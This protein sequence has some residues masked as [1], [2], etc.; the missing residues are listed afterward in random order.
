MNRRSSSGGVLSAIPAWIK[1]S[2]PAILPSLLLAYIIWTLGVNVVYLD[3][4]EMIPIMQK[5]KIGTLAFSDLFLQQ[6]DHRIPFAKIAMLAIGR[7]TGYNTT[8][9]MFFGWILICLSTLLIFRVFRNR[10]S[11]TSNPRFA[12]AFM[13]ASLLLFS[14]C[15]Y[16]ATLWGFEACEYLMCFAV[17]A[18]FYLIEKSRRIDIAFALCVLSAIV[19]SFSFF[20]VGL[21]VWPV[22]MVQVIVSER[23]DL[24]K[25]GIL[26]V[27]GLISFVA[28]F[29]RY[30]RNPNSELSYF[31]TAPLTVGRYFFALVGAPFSN[32]IFPSSDTSVATVFGF[33]IAVIGVFL[34]VQVLR[35]KPRLGNGD[36]IWFSLVVFV[37]LCSLGNAAGR[38]TWT[39]ANALASRYTPVTILG[40]VGLYLF[41]LSISKSSPTRSRRIAAHALLAIILLG[42]AV[43]SNAAWQASQNY[44]QSREMDAYVL[45]TYNIQSDESIAN[46]LFPWAGPLRERAQFLEENKL[47]VFSE[48]AI[49]TST[50]VLAGSNTPSSI[51]M[52]DGQAVKW[53]DNNGTQSVPIIVHLSQQKTITI[54]GW[55][56]DSWA[57]DVASSVFLTID[58]TT[59]VPTLY[60]MDRQ[61]IADR[62]GNSNYRFSGF[63]ASFS[64]SILSVGNH[65]IH[66][67]IVGRGG[68]LLYYSAQTV[69]LVAE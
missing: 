7:L 62:F 46:Y 50:L 12:L 41:A 11:L 47:N 28:Y 54:T 37:G 31:L 18:T 2:L 53:R 25:A 27:F 15:Q 5:F 48:Q 24:R 3:E 39:I 8:A 63:V 10:F 57:G 35:N 1:W 51:D 42:L 60:G 17:V 29:Y 32:V 58:G 65:M 19:A 45:K 40:I 59:D 34:I 30:S 52:I 16:E 55:A 38:S 69:S 67:K 21:I 26:C 9:E 44:S 68:K 56:V 49:D 64:S 66:L 6:N 33:V 22:A 36:G 20:V 43:S 61:D 4:W 14:L 13:P 23:R